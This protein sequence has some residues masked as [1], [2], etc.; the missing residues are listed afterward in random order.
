VLLP[1]TGLASS[2]AA[3]LLVG[4]D[5]PLWNTPWWGK[6]LL[7]LVTAALLAMLSVH[8]QAIARGL[9]TTADS[10][11]AQI[12]QALLQTANNNLMFLLSIVL[13]IG[14]YFTAASVWGNTAASRGLAL[15]VLLFG[16]ITALASG[17]EITVTRSDD[18]VELWHVQPTSRETALLRE[19]LV[20]VAK[21]ETDGVLVTPLFVQAT[22]DGV[23]AWLVRDFVNTTFIQEIGEARTQAVILLR[24][25]T[26]LPDLGGSYVGQPFVIRTFWT[27]REMQ[28]VDYL[29]WWLQRRTRTGATPVE[30]LVLWLR[31]DI[32]DGV[33]SSI[34]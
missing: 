33:E 29:A 21:R 23:V 30:K 20:E 15:G 34:G 24:D 12:F 19:T 9:L 5:H 8:L 1:L 27:T 11:V 16:L 18:P 2:L 3:A 31:Q 28:L 26:E 10:S 22:D 13:T 25:M 4:D 7:A 6:W 17:W 14:I 32:Y